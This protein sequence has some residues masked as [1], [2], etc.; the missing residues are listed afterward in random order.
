MFKSPSSSTQRFL[1]IAL[2]LLALVPSAYLAFH[3][4]AMPHLGFY[5]DDGIYW[6]GAKS[7]A[8]GH[9]Y[10]ILSIPG[11]PF[12]TKYPP[13]FPALLALAWKWNPSFPA[14]LPTAT[15]LT[16][17]V[18]PAYLLLMRALLKQYG[19]TPIEQTVLCL[20]AGLNPFCA[21][22]SFSLMPELLFTSLLLL[23]L[24]LAER[25]TA[26]S[27]IVAGLAYLTRAAALPL[28]I[29]VPLALAL[30]KKYKQAV[31]FAAAMLP[32]IAAWQIW[33]WRHLSPSHDLVTLYYTNYLGFQIYNVGIVDLPSVI[34]H[35]FD[36]LLIGIGKLLL[37]DLGP[38][39]SKHIERVV[40]IAAIAGIAR[41]ARRTGQLQYPLVAL[42]YSAL[43]LVWHYQPDPR[44]VFPLYPLLLAGLWIE[45]RNL[46]E[47]LRTAWQKRGADRVASIIGS[48]AVAAFAVFFA[49]TNFYGLFRL[50]P[51]LMAAYQSD[52][53]NRRPAY[54]WIA[55]Q[56]PRSAGVFAYDD[57]LL[58]LYTGHPSCGLPLPPK[59]LYYD[60]AATDRLVGK[61]PDF[62]RQNRLDY[63]L[64]TSDDFYRDLHQR[65]IHLLAASVQ[66]SPRLE[67]DYSS[68]TASIYRLLP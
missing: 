2:F 21:L 40:A 32:A 66:T 29:T 3:W 17:L 10:K 56:L 58:F 50:I 62:A 30:R 53:Q 1:A 48:G 25:R 33:T 52:L 57:P 20:I 67:R 24:V 45:V 13:L 28:L 65:G 6:I 22:L 38:I 43:L 4:R 14:N 59:L 44:F 27:G 36:A 64:V 26:L 46:L 34:W 35:N 12:Q 54:Q 55:K 9:G 42:A 23:S 63:L 19:F 39:G 5:H 8:E 47:A 60:D 41:L 31:I 61:I 11:Q 49:F 37:F 15:L 16:W 51:D 68:P 18:L 7:L